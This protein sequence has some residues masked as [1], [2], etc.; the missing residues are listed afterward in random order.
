MKFTLSWLKDHFKT[1]AT[2]D[3]ICE[4]LTDLGFEVEGVE[5]PAA[6]LGA[7]SICRVLDASP[8][9]RADRLRVCRLETFPDGRIRMLSKFRSCA[10]RQMLELAWS[11]CLP[12]SGHSFPELNSIS[13]RGRSGALKA[14]ACFARNAN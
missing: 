9:P 10:E 11:A 14:T 7:F 3:D 13:R 6:T 12:R 1:D 2:L 5:N 4:A 8:H